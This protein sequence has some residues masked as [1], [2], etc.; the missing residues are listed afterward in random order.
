MVSRTWSQLTTYLQH[1]KKSNSK[2]RFRITEDLES[3]HGLDL[4]EEGNVM[5][6]FLSLSYV[7]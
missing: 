2:Y 3:I 4:R 7:P 5:Y 1:I 6:I